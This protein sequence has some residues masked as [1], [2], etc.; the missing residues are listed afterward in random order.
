VRRLNFVLFVSF[1]CLG[2]GPRSQAQWTRDPDL[3]DRCRKLLESSVLDFYFP[4][5]VDTR[6]GGY[7]EVIDADG[8]FVGSDEKFLTLQARQLWTSSAM[9][10]AGIRREE[11]LPIAKTGYG[12]LVEHF[13]DAKYGGY[14]SKVTDA[15]V[16]LDRRK[17]VYL[18]A[19]ALYA[20]TAYHRASGLPEPLKLAQKLFQ[21]I[22]EKAYDKAAGGYQEFFSEQ[23]EPITD[24]GAAGYVGAINTKT[25]NTHLH[26]LEAYA[27]LYRVWPDPV[28]ATRLA[29]LI[30]INTVT[31]RNPQVG[32][33]LDGWQRNWRLIETPSN[34]RASYGHDVECAWLVLDAAEALGRQTE[35]FRTWATS[36]VDYSLR[37]GYD[38]SHGGFFYSGPLNGPAD[39]T[40]KEWWVQ[41]EAL[42]SMLDLERLTGD[43]T[44]R[45]RFRETLDFIERHQIAEEGGWWA[46]R[47]ADGSPAANQS[48]TSPWQ[49]AYHNG[50][51]LLYAWQ[52]LRE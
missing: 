34:L 50:R 2:F 3:A 39:D 31:V 46:T 30:H 19:F 13:R 29:E 9:A 10:E 52:R 5:C 4:D 20:L 37:H 41:A 51:A 33:N 47:Q 35:L 16:P 11:L 22:E 27:A 28:L 48:R 23:W 36:L 7:L 38:A 45:D 6:H 1:V 21:T 43:S 25:Y 14:Y 12:F 8:K 40:R 15:G 24:P 49:G 17:H 42:V 32:C 44:Y 26:L 18:N